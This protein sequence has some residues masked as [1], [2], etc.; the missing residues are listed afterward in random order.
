FGSSKKNS[1]RPAQSRSIE[2]EQLE[3]R[4]T[5]T[6]I[7][8]IGGLISILG[9]NGPLLPDDNLTISIA[10]NQLTVTEA[11]TTLTGTV[12]GVTAANNTVTIDFATNAAA[13]ALT[14]ISINLQD[15]N[16]TLNVITGLDFRSLPINNNAVSILFDG[17]G[18]G[19]PAGNNIFTFQGITA[20]KTSTVTINNF[21][22]LVN[23]DAT[24]N[25]AIIQAS[26]GNFS[27]S[28][29]GA[30]TV[31]STAVGS[32]GVAFESSVNGNTI[33]INNQL[34]VNTPL[35]IRGVGAADKIA[36]NSIT[37]TGTSFSGS[38]LGSLSFRTQGDIS[39]RQMLERSFILIGMQ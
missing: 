17:D 15:G 21:G 30:M 39:V 14:G 11:N 12:F 9:S 22:S 18:L 32:A 34:V 10:N 25:L 2:I 19:S 26:G 16:D 27:L 1:L 33:A 23:T 36:I 37:T 29:N 24:G 35:F 3:N 38:A 13:K 20:S 28:K 5:P 4:I 6:T 7:T 31:S 8:N